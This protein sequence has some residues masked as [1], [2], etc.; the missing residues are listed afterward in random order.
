MT[1]STVSDSEGLLYSPDK[2]VS[3]V[4]PSLCAGNGD[5]DLAAI[6]PGMPPIIGTG[7]GQLGWLNDTSKRADSEIQR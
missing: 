7:I 4:Q 3:M 5:S 1:V 6:A 2:H